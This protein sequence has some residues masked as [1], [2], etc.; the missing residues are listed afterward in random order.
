MTT[1]IEKFEEMAHKI[2]SYLKAQFPLY[3][4][5]GPESLG[6]EKSTGTYLSGEWVGSEQTEDELYFAATFQWLN[7]EG[8]VSGGEQD[9][10]IPV[11]NAVLT[12]KGLA[13][14]RQPIYIG[15]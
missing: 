6:I 4:R 12:E 8:Y 11:T 1:N 10:S 2:L 15:D 7:R 9:G 5:V 3:S 13:L 14:A